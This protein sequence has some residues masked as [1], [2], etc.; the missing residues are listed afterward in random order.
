MRIEILAFQR[1]WVVCTSHRI[2]F[3]MVIF[4]EQTPQIS[5]ENCTHPTSHPLYMYINRQKIT[6]NVQVSL[7]SSQHSFSLSSAF[8]NNQACI[9]LEVHKDN[10]L[11]WLQKDL[12]RHTWL[13]C[14]IS[15][16]MKPSISF[17]LVSKTGMAVCAIHPRDCST[18]G[19]CFL[20]SSI[21]TSLYTFCA[22]NAISEHQHRE[23]H[24]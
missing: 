11:I 23:W 1:G 12:E 4:G 5:M 22:R 8:W 14:R 20:S 2:F 16:L 7:L 13:L 18:A 3:S 19:K 24:N 10:K 9:G 21:S 15:L 17:S 6:F